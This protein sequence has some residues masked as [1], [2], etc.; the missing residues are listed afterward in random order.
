MSVN[1]MTI[2]IQNIYI[3]YIQKL[4]IIQGSIANDTIASLIREIAET[5]SKCHLT[6][7]N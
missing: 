4:G 3:I 6:G 7:F 2:Y 5:L 1:D